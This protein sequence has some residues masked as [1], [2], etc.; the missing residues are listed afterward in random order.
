MSWDI[1]Q[2]RRE[3]H[4][5]PEL[6][7]EEDKTHEYVRD[8][9][10]RLDGITLKYFQN[11]KGILVE[12]SHGEGDYQLFRADMDAL[13]ITENTGVDYS[14]RQCGMMH[15]CGHDIH[16]SVLLGLIE[17]VCEKKP[18]ANLLFLFQPAE[19]GKGGA[20]SILSEGIIQRY[21]I[22]SVYA[23]HVA[24]GL[25]VGTISSREGIFFGIPQE[26]DV[27][28]TGRS[29]HAAYPE[30]GRNALLM[31]LTFI[32]LMNTDIEDLQRE[33]RAIFHIGKMVSGTIRN[34]VPD[35]CVIEG[36]HRS[37]E[38]DAR[39]AMNRY[40]A[41]NARNAAEQL[42]GE[43]Q[44]DLLCSYDPVVNDGSLERK[45]RE[46]CASLNYTYITAD[47]AMTGEDFGFFTSMYPGL[48]F[49]LGSGSD[50]PLHSDK[51]LPDEDCLEI[52]INTFYSLIQE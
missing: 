46:H 32:T 44:V 19:E 36:T 47:A 37:L 51:F 8:L 24:S 4:Q 45:L 2:I 14:S 49:W 41:E 3:L 12:Y 42:D 39:D 20:E 29:A 52:G 13:P 10:Q 17:R 27:V 38:K 1:R 23:L 5:I 11:S 28:F 16:M 6:A 33:H 9:L 34:I 48:L 30:Q 21:P 26:F 22:H 25:P 50:S 35:K 43:Y 7:F 31:G 40:I 18:K 15:A